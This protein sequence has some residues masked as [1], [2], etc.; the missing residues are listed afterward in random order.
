MSK[1]PTPKEIPPTP[2]QVDA[3]L[4]SVISASQTLINGDPRHV[5]NLRAT[6]L[7]FYSHPTFQLIL[8]LPSQ[9]THTPP[10]PDNQLK[11]ELLEIKSTITA[12]SKAV[13]G[14]QPKAK[15]PQAP[16]SQPPPPKGKPSA[17][18]QGP[19]NTS[20]HTFASKAAVKPR[21]SLVLDLGAPDP[22]KQ[23]SAEIVTTLNVKLQ[24][25]GYSQV[26]FSAAK[27]T[28]KGNLVLT[29]HHAVTQANLTD[30][31]FLITSLLREAFPTLFPQTDL[32]PARANVKWSKILINSVPTGVSASR[33]PW[34]PV[35]C[36]QTLAAHNPSYATLKV[37]QKPSWVRNPTTYKIGD[38]SSLVVAFEDPDG[39]QRRSILSNRQLFLLG[40]RAKVSRWKEKPRPTQAPNP[41]NAPPPDLADI[42]SS[43]SEDEISSTVRALIGPAPPVPASSV[44]QGAQPPSQ[45]PSAQR[46]KRAAR[47]QKPG[48]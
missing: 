7:Q 32:I 46:P 23:P 4:R 30:A 5:T 31:T 28:N 15:G 41:P 38:H 22:T 42:A 9:S 17:Q 20:P 11:A 25:Q 24:H 48:A 16:Q 19:V 35:E 21:P 6:F 34:T 18:G 3:T 47:S 36:H 14:L 12:L 1:V 40:I 45:Q 2:Q 44:R 39:S 26:K 37:T 8:G 10:M 43:E 29:A 27:W 13:T 33:G